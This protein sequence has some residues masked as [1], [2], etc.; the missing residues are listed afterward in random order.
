MIT[1]FN[2][3]KRRAAAILCALVFIGAFVCSLI[4]G[5]VSLSS[6]LAGIIAAAIAAAPFMLAA[7]IEYI[8]SK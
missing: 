8:Y 6:V 7:G 3:I 1:L 4:I 2:K 5:G